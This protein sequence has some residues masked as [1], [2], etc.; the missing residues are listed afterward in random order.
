M[1]N[2]WLYEEILFYTVQ[3]IRWSFCER[4]YILG[5]W[6]EYQQFISDTLTHVKGLVTDHLSQ[7]CKCLNS[8]A[9]S[10]NF[11]LSLF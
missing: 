6:L 8:G 5:I 4:F 11:F 10:A 1:C 2:H 3:S 7:S 9:Y